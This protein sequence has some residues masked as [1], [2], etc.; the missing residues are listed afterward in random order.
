MFLFN[1]IINMV[2]VSVILVV[3]FEIFV[4]FFFIFYQLAIYIPYFVMFCFVTPICDTSFSCFSSTSVFPWLSSQR[5]HCFSYIITSLSKYNR[6]TGCR[7]KRIQYRRKQKKS[8]MCIMSKQN[9]IYMIFIV[10]NLFF[11]LTSK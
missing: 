2:F 11:D 8:L 6:Y 1:K 9:Y 4:F 10:N 5:S 3:D 7:Q